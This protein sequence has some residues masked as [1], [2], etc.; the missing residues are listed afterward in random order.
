MAQKKGLEERLRDGVVL[1]GEGY[2]FELERRGYVQHGAFVPEV[3]ADH[4]SAVTELHREYLRAGSDIIVALTYYAHRTGLRWVGRE[5]ELE[6]INRSAIRLAREVADEGDALV[7][8]DLCNTFV[9]APADDAGTA[10]QVRAMYEEQVQWAVDGGVDLILA[11]TLMHMREAEIALELI[12]AAGLPSVINLSPI[13][14]QTGDGYDF[15]DACRILSD[16]GATVVGLNC[17]RG[18]ETFL[19]LV[20]RVLDAC[21]GYVSALPVPYRTGADDPTFFTL[22]APD[23][24]L[25]SPVELEPFLMTRYEMA[26]FAVTARDLGVRYLGVCCGGAPYHVRE[27]AE[28]LGR[29]TPASRYSADL[30]RLR[31][32]LQKLL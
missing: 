32:S 5:A 19:P 27:M 20:G 7:A 12:Q 25:G 31:V 13:Q 11:E 14:D 15:Q 16:R 2:I 6:D 17:A 10:P 24:C 26:K 9:Y 28:A 18:P 30:D 4:P 8:G 21:D 3:V 1:C 29:T 23:C 22:R